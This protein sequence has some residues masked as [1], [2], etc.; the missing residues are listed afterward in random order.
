MAN[1]T[2]PICWIGKGPTWC[3][4]QFLQCPVKCF[5]GRYQRRSN[6]PRSLGEQHL[7]EGQADRTG[8]NLEPSRFVTGGSRSCHSLVAGHQCSRFAGKGQQQIHHHHRMGQNSATMAARHGHPGGSGA[9]VENTWDL[10]ASESQE[11]RS[12]GIDSAASG[13]GP[14]LRTLFSLDLSWVCESGCDEK[15]S[16]SLGVVHKLTRHADQFLESV[17]VLAAQLWANWH[18][19]SQ[20]TLWDRTFVHMGMDQY[21]LI[22]FLVGWTSIYQ[23]FW[24]SP[25]VPGFDTLPYLS[26]IPSSPATLRSL[27]IS[28]AG[29]LHFLRKGFEA[30]RCYQLSPAQINRP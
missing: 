8:W 19:V 24:C 1:G 28:D 7:S 10:C 30:S 27:R 9:D 26:I 5:S 2:Q 21:L 4:S 17:Q 18:R 14:S 6:F 22:P 23:L 16:N 3:Q 11:S 29:L 15:C 20:S 13:F 12:F 25:G